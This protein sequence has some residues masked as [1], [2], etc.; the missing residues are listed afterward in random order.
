[1]GQAGQ[2]GLDARPRRY[3]PPVPIDVDVLIVSYRSV[4]VLVDTLESIGR[5]MPGARVLIREHADDESSISRLR[6]L[7]RSRPGVSVEHDPSNPGFGAGCNSL[8]AAATAR[9]LLF[10]NPDARVLAWPWAEA[11]EPSPAV[12]GPKMIDSGPEGDHWG[13][14]YRIVDEV[15][16]SWLRRRG[17]APVGTGFVSG[18]ALLVPAAA[19]RAVGGFDARYFMFYEDI[20]LCERLN[21]AGVPT[22]LADGWVVHHARAH[23]TRERFGESLLWS[24]RSAC[25]FHGDRGESLR[26]FRA[27]VAIDSVARAVLAALRRN[28]V[29]RRGYL[30]LARRAARDLLN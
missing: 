3:C 10:L 15:G 7:A 17:P 21:R 23:S 28:P 2:G 19:F 1:M 8:A 13:V 25:L 5:T 22:Q 18:A 11:I 30:T 12:I 24:Y 20:D 9:W 14:R 6:A 16:R 4:D 29:R 26:L 27:Y